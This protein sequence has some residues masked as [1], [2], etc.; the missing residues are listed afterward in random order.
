MIMKKIIQKRLWVPL[1]SIMLFLGG[2]A[3]SRGTPTLNPGTYT[4]SAQG[5]GGPVTVEV[6]VSGTSI[7]A[8]TV[9]Q[10]SETAGIADP[11]LERIPREIVN[12]QSIA[13]DSVTGATLTSAAIRNAVADAIKQAGGKVSDFSNPPTIT[14]GAAETYTTDIV[15]VGAGG[16]GLSAGV[17]A[18][19]AGIQV[20]LIEKAAA[21]GGISAFGAGIGAV[22][23]SFQKDAG[24]SFTKDEIYTHMLKYTNAIVYAPLLRRIVNQSGDTVDWLKKQFNMDIRLVTP[25]IWGGEVYDTYHLI[26]PYGPERFAP[27]IEN[28]KK[29][30]GKLLL[31][32]EGKD[33]IIENDRITG[34]AAEKP[35]GTKVIVRAKAV[36]LATGGAFG[37][38]EM[39]IQYTN[40]AAYAMMSPSISDGAGIRMALDAGAATT[41]EMFVEISEIGMTPGVA[42]A[43]KFHI[44]LVSVAALLMVNSQGR[45]YFNEGLFK[46]QPLNQG[47]AAV[48]S[49]GP[50]YVILDQK[51]VD[52]L[53]SGGLKALLPPGER[54]KQSGQ[55]ERLSFYGSTSGVPPMFAGAAYPLDDL[56]REMR[57]G[58]EQG[59]V[60]K[61]DSI[62]ELTRITGLTNLTATVN[63]YRELAA[64]KN[65]VDLLKRDVYLTGIST[66]PYYAV[67]FL[68]GGFNTLGGIKVNENLEALNADNQSIP[69]LYVAG[70]DG[71]SMFHKPYYDI[72]GTSMMYAFGSGRI[73][74]SEAAE[75][76]KNRD[77]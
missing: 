3:T 12:Y 37:N 24:L 26:Y 1:V 38:P 77:R 44:N 50:Y 34:V 61:A 75:Y 76:I 67:K 42:P 15:I 14:A 17:Q 13:V 46:E 43:P 20:I 2:C 49:N 60:W 66:P 9:I 19:Q 10:H 55:L 40:S 6:T 72:C 35:D 62:E 58:L 7:T 64:N 5:N 22:E 57:F 30:G 71:G 29:N 39:L 11:A 33:L 21:P 54:E 23:S 74:G 59:Y 31:E 47:G 32:T 25:N 28:I 63:R 65:D 8:I 36:I 70:V 16:S 69:G 52:T 56:E 53:V 45:R 4:A 18:A 51:T 27:L 48:A 68:P 73:A 41:N